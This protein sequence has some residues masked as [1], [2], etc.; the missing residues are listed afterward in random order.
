VARMAASRTGVVSWVTSQATEALLQLSDNGVS[1]RTLTQ[2]TRLWGPRLSPT[3]RQIVFAK[4]DAMNPVLADLWIY[5][6]ASGTDQRLTSGGVEQR[7]FNDATWSRDGRWLAMSAN[8]SAGPAVKHLYLMPADAS[9]APRKLLDRAGTQWPSDFSPDGKWLVFTDRPDARLR[10]IWVVP[11][12]GSSAPRAIVKTPY[13]AAA[14]RIS[15]DGRWI[16][17]HADDTGQNEVYVQPFPGPGARVR[18]ST[19]GGRM[20]AWSRG[21]AELYYAT[22][23]ALEIATVSAGAESTVTARRQSLPVAFPEFSEHAQYDVS[24][25]GKRMVLLTLPSAPNRILISTSAV[26]STPR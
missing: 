3:G 5:D 25:D 15:P 10:S 18:I 17:Y 14:G 22:A 6:V 21:G 24:A 19:A 12:D 11:V 13:S 2:N 4:Y 26:N 8:D 20:P 16:A 7:D 23:T 1:P 9:A